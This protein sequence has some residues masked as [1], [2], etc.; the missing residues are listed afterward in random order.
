[1]KTFSKLLVLGA[2]L[3]VSTSM[4]YA[5]TLGAGAIGIDASHN[6]TPTFTSTSLSFSNGYATVSVARDS[7]LSYL[8]D[9]ATI[10]GITYANVSSATPVELYSVSGLDYYLT[11]VSNSITNGV[12][13]LNGS[14]YFTDAGYDNTSA[15]LT[16]TA[17]S[18]GITD[19]ET[20]SNIT[21][22]PEPGSLLLL[23]T[24]LLSAAGIARRKFASKLV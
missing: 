13:T 20:T 22:T 14:G 3:A 2:A 5:D 19:F 7:L 16:L 18:T 24:G 12:L 1:M 15:D 11:S 6:D 4:A 9:D 23:G 21:P 10:Y 8:G 17:S